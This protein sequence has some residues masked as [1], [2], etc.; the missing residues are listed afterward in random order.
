MFNLIG[1]EKFPKLVLKGGA[2]DGSRPDFRYRRILDQY[3]FGLT[4]HQSYPRLPL[5][6]LALWL[7]IKRYGQ[8]ILYHRLT[9]PAYF[10][11]A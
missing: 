4:R 7:K 10:Q 9:L 1:C 8:G 3:L 5:L 6:A 11:H 2:L